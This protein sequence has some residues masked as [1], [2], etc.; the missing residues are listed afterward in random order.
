M[1]EVLD[2]Q[3]IGKKFDS[4]TRET[5]GTKEN[6]PNTV[7][8]SS[9]DVTN[10]CTNMP[11]HFRS[12]TNRE[13]D[14]ETSRILTKKIHS[15]FSDIFMSVSWFYGTFKLQVRKGSHPYQALPRRVA[16]ALQEPLKE[17]LERLQKQQLIVPLD[18]DET[19]EWCNSLVLAPKANGMVR[20]CLNLAR[21]NKIIIRSIDR[22]LTL[23]NILPRPAGVKYLTL[24]IMSSG[25]HNLSEISSHHT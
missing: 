23:N 10:D 22:G 2:Q 24:I 13:A 1:C 3:Q 18:F 16:Y 17:D 14:K 12:S 8:T 19:S 6:R 20:L 9:V 11:D 15:D 7:N 25:Y 21:L 5:S 4:Q